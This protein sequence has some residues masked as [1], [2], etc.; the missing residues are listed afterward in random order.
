MVIDSDKLLEAGQLITIRPH[1]RFVHFPEHTHNY[2]EV[3]Y[4]C[5]RDHPCGGW[6]ELKLKEEGTAVLNQHAWSRKSSL[7]VRMTLR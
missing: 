1:T 7:R 4:M 6:R 3:I 5:R 2:V